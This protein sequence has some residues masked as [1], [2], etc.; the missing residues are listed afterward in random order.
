MDWYKLTTWLNDLGEDGNVL[1][2]D[3]ESV[4]IGDYQYSFDLSFMSD[5]GFI[6]RLEQSFMDFLSVYKNYTLA[7]QAS[8]KDQDKVVEEMLKNI[9]V[10]TLYFY[11]SESKPKE[12]KPWWKFW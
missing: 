3:D 2:F 12:Y 7:N 8:W 9:V 5:V 6:S 11:T 4:L 1:V 10:P